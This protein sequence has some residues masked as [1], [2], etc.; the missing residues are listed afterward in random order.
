MFIPCF[1]AA[2]DISCQLLEEHEAKDMLSVLRVYNSCHDSLTAE[3]HFCALYIPNQVCYMTKD[4]SART[5]I[6]TECYT[7]EL[8]AVCR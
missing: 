5:H 8:A 2:D 7:N 1:N 3:K 4:M 6:I